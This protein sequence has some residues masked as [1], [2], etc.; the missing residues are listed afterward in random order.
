MTVAEQVLSVF[1]G[2]KGYLD[3]VDLKDISDFE[4]KLLKSVNQKNL[5]Y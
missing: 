3:D 2:V 4:K 1:C 5:K